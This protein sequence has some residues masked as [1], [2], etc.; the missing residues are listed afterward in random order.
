MEVFTNTS[1]RHEKATLLRQVTAAHQAP[2]LYYAVA[3]RSTALVKFLLDQGGD[4]WLNADPVP[5]DDKDCAN[6]AGNGGASPFPQGSSSQMAKETTSDLQPTQVPVVA[7]AVAQGDHD[8][9]HLLLKRGAKP[10]AIPSKLWLRVVLKAG[11]HAVPEADP[12][13]EE[14]QTRWCVAVE[15]S[16]LL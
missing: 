10:L 3:S 7:L 15:D 16:K 11:Y 2:L 6:R 5:S 4:S 9:V 12:L 8:M 13:E 1:R 14:L